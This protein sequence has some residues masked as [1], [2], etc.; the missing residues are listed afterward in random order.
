[1]VSNLYPPAPE[2][3]EVSTR[4]RRR[5]AFA[6]VILFTL[7]A[8]HGVMTVFGPRIREYFSLSVEQYGTM[9]GLGGLGQNVSLLLVGLMISRFGVR[10]ITEL[11]LGGIGGCF[12]LIG[13]GAN[14]LFLKVSLALHGLFSGLSR[15]ALPA[16][17]VA[18]YPSR[19]RRMISVQLVCWSAMGIVIPLWANQLLRWT[20]EG[21]DRAFVNLFFGPF[22]IAG[23]IV[24]AGWALLSLSRQPALQGSDPSSTEGQNTT[25]ERLRFRELLGVR[26]LIIVV[27]VTL[28]ASADGTIFQF[29]PFFMKHHF[30]QLS[31]AAWALSGHNVAYLIT[32]SLLSLMP[33][34]VGQRAILTLAGPIGGSLLLVM[35]WQDHAITVPLIYTLA[36]LFYAA[37][38]PVLLSEISSRSMGHF[39]SVMSGAYLVSNAASFLLLKGIGRMVDTTGDYRVALS[40]VACGF[41][42]F[43]LVAALAGLGKAPTSRNTATS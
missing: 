36:S 4:R 29:L 13:L 31:L 6:V 14:L 17:L 10:R 8:Y 28:H 1:M 38:F 41:I 32:R 23:C 5:L 40:V 33:E 19:K 21:G 3:E 43:G 20:R 9:I 16:F 25:G 34:G 35:L 37:E 24:M 12:V 7:T 30:D 22:L 18:L 39:A 26:P 2:I 15:V 42:A 27:L 11:A